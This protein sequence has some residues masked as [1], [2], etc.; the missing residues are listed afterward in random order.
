MRT[1]PVRTAVERSELWLLST[2]SLDIQIDL[3]PKDLGQAL[4]RRDEVDRR[5]AAGVWQCCRTEGIVHVLWA[6]K[7][8]AQRPIRTPTSDICRFDARF[9]RARFLADDRVRELP[10]ANSSL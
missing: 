7:S 9:N 2:R 3:V 5:P 4:V 10:T 1:A 6:W 8:S